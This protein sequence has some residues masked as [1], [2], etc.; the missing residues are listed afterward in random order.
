[1]SFQFRRARVKRITMFLVMVRAVTRR[2]LIQRLRTLM[3]KLSINLTTT[4][5]IRG[6]TSLRKVQITRLR[7]K[8]R[9]KGNSANVRGIL[10][11]RRILTKGITIRVLSSLSRATNDNVTTTMTKRSRGVGITESNRNPR[12][13]NRRGRQALRSKSRS[14]ISTLMVPTSLY[15]RFN[16]LNFRYFLASRSILSVIVRTR[17]LFLRFPVPATE[18][19]QSPHPKP[20]PQRDPPREPAKSHYPPPTT[21]NPLMFQRRYLP[22]SSVYT[23][24]YSAPTP[25]TKANLPI[26][27]YTTWKRGVAEL[28]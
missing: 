24:T 18:S 14:G 5:L 25:R 21:T 1:M 9:L 16:G 11:S 3:V 7:R 23:K 22:R 19:I 12:R 28:F 13:I 4:K 6:N 2:G 26:S 10:R 15:A 20:T 17:K 27:K 8:R